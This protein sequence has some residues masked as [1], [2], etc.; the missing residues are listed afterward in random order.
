MVGQLLAAR[1]IVRA[2]RGILE[3]CKP[4]FEVTVIVDEDID[5]YGSCVIDSR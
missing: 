4:F 3:V 2:F 1:G 5:W